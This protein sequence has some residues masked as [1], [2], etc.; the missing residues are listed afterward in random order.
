MNE[1]EYK[2]RLDWYEKKYGPYFEKRGI[3][4]TKNLLRMPNSYEWL[5]LIIV[6]FTLFMSYAYNI[7]TKVC[8]ETLNNIEAI[9]C[10]V[11]KVKNQI[12]ETNAINNVNMINNLT[13]GIKVLSNLTDIQRGNTN[14]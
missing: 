3:H 11:C 9:S 12:S 5:I 13:E 7:E 1:E 4:N 8:R 6:G 14:E 2:K 10:E